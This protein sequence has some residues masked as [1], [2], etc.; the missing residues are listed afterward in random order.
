MLTVLL[1]ACVAGPGGPNPIET[2]APG[3]DASP[4]GDVLFRGGTVVGSG[5][6]AL[7]VKAGVITEVGVGLEAEG[8]AVVDVSGRWLAPSFIDSHVHLAYLPAEE[9]MADG[10]VA[11]VVDLAAPLSFFDVP[12]PS[13]SVVASGPMVT[14]EGGYPTRSWGSGG[15]GMECDEAAAAGA[16]VATLKE[17][18]AG[19]IKLPVTSG[20][21]LDDA[22]LRAAVDAAHARALPVVSHALADDEAAR[23][24]AAGA[25]V[26]AHT[27]TEPLASTTRDAWRG[28]AV[29]STLAAF[30]GGDATIANLAAL[31]EAGVTVLYGTDFGNR[32]TPGIDAD[33]L[34]LLRMAGLSPQDILDAG[35]RLPARQWGFDELG[36]LE[37][38]KAGSLLF[39]AQDPLVDPLVLAEPAE[40]WLRGV[41]PR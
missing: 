8:A 27:P 9:E 4:V 6:L 17:A 28:R 36:S 32:R 7:R 21:Q 10:G 13:L 18:G 26:L 16:A 31:H 25:D 5:P 30:G 39:L 15:Y 38:G 23:A 11:G 24:A 22:A 35:T 3:R 29:I 2:A 33:E 37:V 14:A 19:V 40:V 1:F 34:A 20:P 12:H 41:R